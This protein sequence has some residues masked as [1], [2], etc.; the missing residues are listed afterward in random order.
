MVE[1][2]INQTRT[3]LK[4]TINN[5]FKEKSTLCSIPSRNGNLAARPRPGYFLLLSV[6]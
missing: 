1:S 6:F 3:I 2:C 4:N 5:E